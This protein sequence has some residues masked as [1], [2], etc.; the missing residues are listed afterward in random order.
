MNESHDYIA[1]RHSPFLK[2]LAKLLWPVY[3]RSARKVMELVVVGDGL[4]RLKALAGQ[5]VVIC[6]NHASE[7]DAEVIFGL[8]RLAK[9]DF[10][11]LTAHEIF[12]GHRGWNFFLLPEMG[13]YSV[14]RGAPDIHAYRT[15]MQILLENELKLVVFPE[16]EVSHFNEV[17]MP[18]E[19]GVARIS[20]SALRKL[21]Q[22]GIDEDITLLPL[23]IMYDY[24]D[25]I[26]GALEKGLTR[27]EKH[28]KT[29][30]S[31]TFEE[32]LT[33]VTLHLIASMEEEHHIIP[34]RNLDFASRAFRLREKIID[35][36]AAQAGLRRPDGAEQLEFAH[37]VKSALCDRFFHRKKLRGKELVAQ[38]ILYKQIVTAI[39]L[40]VLEKSC[41]FTAPTKPGQ[42]EVAEVVHWLERV[43]FGKNTVYGARRIM[44]Q[45]G[46][47]IAL[48][49][50]AT[51]FEQDDDDAGLQ[52]NKR[53]RLALL[54]M[55]RNLSSRRT[56]PENAAP[57]VVL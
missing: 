32:R 56:K 28:L 33:S 37:K 51:Q 44:M 53:I 49:A 57:P 21:K 42:D 13:C 2:W 34:D 45:M 40:T 19:P 52:V 50:Y 9:E 15:T 54:T 18:L 6:P 43:L 30:M 29:S 7:D 12:H 23:A 38:K 27:I 22:E 31:G 41:I 39:D 55:L 1:P 10:Y 11:Y 36:V 16:G 14:T 24:V 26:Q 20:F 4:E 8:S 17:V 3:M 25:N 35:D 46:E 47:P 48:S 5:R